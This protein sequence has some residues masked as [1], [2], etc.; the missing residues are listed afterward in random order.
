MLTF[1]AASH[2]YRYAGDVVPS[3]TQ[4]LEPISSYAGVPR[5]ILQAAAAR[6]TYIHE[7]CEMALWETLDWDSV[8]PEYRGYVEA[9]GKFLADSGVEVELIEERVYHPVLCYAGTA[10]LICR[11]P[12]R[13]KM[14]RAVVD[15]KTSLKMM[16]SV[17]PQVAA[18]Q[19]AQ[20]ASQPK[21]QEKVLDRYGL[22]LKKD[23]TYV[24]EPYESPNDFN[25]FK[26]CLVIHNFLKEKSK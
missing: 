13:G 9:F 11:L 2:T 24:L 20:N 21:G 19:E 22:H 18:Y 25:V 15:Y 12:R 5:N 23:G 14:R 10:D 17:G 8:M 7:C 6:G 1:D 26:S 16:P 4:V 3:V